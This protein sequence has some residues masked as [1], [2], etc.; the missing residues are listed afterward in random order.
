VQ[1]P[2]DVRDEEEFYATQMVERRVTDVPIGRSP[3]RGINN[4]NTT[5]DDEDPRWGGL[6]TTTRV[7]R[8]VDCSN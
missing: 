1:F 7:R 2:G 4:P 8:R 6:W 5:L 3:R